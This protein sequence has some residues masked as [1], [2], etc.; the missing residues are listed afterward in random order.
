MEGRDGLVVAN[1]T[2]NSYYAKDKYAL[3]VY[4]PFSDDRV[5]APEENQPVY[6][7]DFHYLVDGLTFEQV[8][9]DIYTKQNKDFLQ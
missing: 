2:T 9:Q 7:E 5:P 8:I 6:T 3:V 1:G 4:H